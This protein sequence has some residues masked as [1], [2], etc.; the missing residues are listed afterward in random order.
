MLNGTIFAR[1]VPKH[2][3]VNYGSIGHQFHRLC[4]SPDGDG[5][6]IYGQRYDPSLEPRAEFFHLT[7][8]RCGPHRLLVASEVDCHT[9]QGEGVELKIGKLGGLS[10][11]TQ[12]LFANVPIVVRATSRE[13]APGVWSIHRVDTF[14]VQQMLSDEVKARSMAMFA[15]VLTQLRRTMR[16]G[17]VYRLQREQ[18]N[19]VCFELPE[20]S[21]PLI[22]SEEV[23]W[24]RARVRAE[25]GGRE[26]SE[27]SNA[28]GWRRRAPD[29]GL[30]DR[31]RRETG[32][33]E[34]GLGRAP[35]TSE[36]R[37]R[38]RPSRVRGRGASAFSEA[39][40]GARRS[41]GGGGSAAA[42]AWRRAFEKGAD[43]ASYDDDDDDDD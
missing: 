13:H 36:V 23:D 8:L 43:A 21:A 42:R 15:R 35:Y 31:D 19:I 18:R 41:T 1:D 17:C 39:R 29:N 5:P 3:C 9:Q 7:D 22:T 27:T 34:Q 40:G 33:S 37:R 20:P 11:W 14:D 10:T 2:R 16:E 25:Q 32:R 26:D 12:C 6:R 24:L 4:V 28:E 30:V 38:P